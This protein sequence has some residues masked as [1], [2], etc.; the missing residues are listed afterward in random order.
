MAET[1]PRIELFYD[2]ERDWN[3]ELR[4]LR[5]ILLSAG[6]GE[7]WKWRQPVYT[8]HGGNIATLWGFRDAAGIGFFKGVLLTDPE[9]IL[10]P[11]G[12]NSRSSMVVRFTDV[13]AIEAKAGVLRAYLEEA[14][15]NE[16][17]GLKVAFPK[18]D[19]EYPEELTDRLD[20]DPE[21]REA[22]D[23]L[24]PGR[25]R[26][27]VL[28]VSGAKQSATRAGRIDKARDRILAGKGLNDR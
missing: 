20:A 4:A 27:W 2:S 12:E 7:E 1:D 25:R 17:K 10:E 26:S 24:T 11:A 13:A 19:L 8:A 16:R 28:H 3:A 5:K 14:A 6:L 21:L 9:K 15:E 23:A 18:D 22:F